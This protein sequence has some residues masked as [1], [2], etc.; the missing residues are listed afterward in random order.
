MDVEQEEYGSIL[1]LTNFVMANSYCRRQE[2]HFNS[3]G[4]L[5]ANTS[6]YSRN[7]IYERKNDKFRS[8]R[9]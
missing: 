5:V 4:I 1:E 3:G 9:L 6:V 8:W 2:S 7:K